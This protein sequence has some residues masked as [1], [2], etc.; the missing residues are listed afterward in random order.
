MKKI[1]TLIFIS[2]FGN[3]FAQGGDLDTSFNPGT[4]FD[5]NP[6][7]IVFQTDGKILVGGFFTTYN[8]VTVNR[9]VRLNPD[10]SIDTS[11]ATGTGFDSNV[12]ALALQPDGKILVGG[13][14]LTYNG[15]QVN[16][17]ARLNIDGSIDNSFFGGTRANGVVRTIEIQPADGKIIIGG[18]FN[19]YDNITRLRIARLNADGTLDLTFNSTNGADSDVFYASLQTDGKIVVVGQFLTYGTTTVNRVGRLNTDGSLDT[20]FNTGGAGADDTVNF[21]TIQSDGKILIGGVFERYNGALR[22]AFARLNANGSL[23]TGFISNANTVVQSINLQSDGRI[24]ISGTFT[25]YNGTS[26]RRIARVNSDGTLDT[27]FV[28]LMPVSGVIMVSEL[29]ANNAIYIGGSFLQ[30][31]GIS[32]ARIARLVNDFTLGL[33]DSVA[34]NNEISVFPNPATH[35]FELKTTSKENILGI[36]IYN[37][38]GQQVYKT[39]TLGNVDVS[40]LSSGIYL[41]K[42]N[43]LTE[44]KTLKLV[45]Q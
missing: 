2:L 35:F 32:R 15:T 25:D 33:D 14:F 3:L 24:I 8:G 18:A 40:F 28:P 1:I 34:N 11:F 30:Y 27:T 7:A 26:I 16:R 43:T 21:V 29:D 10:G 23:D 45:K 39:N 5:N 31:D 13:G 4:G 44:S 6:Q 22:S 17:I 9:I 19:L 36:E 20:S 37:L 38:N 12:F 41:V 42:V